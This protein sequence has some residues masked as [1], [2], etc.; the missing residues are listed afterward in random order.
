[1]GENP[2]FP[3]AKKAAVM[4]GTLFAETILA[5]A[6]WAQQ[7]AG[8]MDASDLFETLRISLQAGGHPHMETRGI[9]FSVPRQFCAH[10]AV[11]G[12][13]SKQRACPFLI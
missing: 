2:E 4:T 10:P 12:T 13:A 8:H 9:K 5:S 6:R 1:M 11:I 7:Q 3:L